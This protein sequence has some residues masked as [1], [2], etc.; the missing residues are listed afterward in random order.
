MIDE[1]KFPNNGFNIKV[2]AKEDI[3]KTIDANIIDKDVAFEIIKNLELDAA[4]FIHQG[5]WTGIPFIGNIRVPL[6]R[7]YYRQQEADNLYNDA[8][9]VLDRQDYIIF[10]K[11]VNYNNQLKA[12]AERCYKYITSMAIARNNKKYKHLKRYYSEVNAK[13]IMYFSYNVIA[14]ENEY[15]EVDNG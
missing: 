2:V 7:Q 5:R 13:L 14:V 12:K 8:K 1:I 9:E 15:E 3:L 6:A 11:N 4:K 10:R